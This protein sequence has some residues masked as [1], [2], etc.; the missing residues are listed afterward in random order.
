MVQII[1]ALIVVV[2]GLFAYRFF[3]DYMKH[4]KETWAEPGNS[5][6][7]AIW[8]AVCFFQRSGYRISH[9]PRYFIV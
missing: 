3:S 6:G 7:L 5:V 9:S 4:R 2:N 1:L 8:G